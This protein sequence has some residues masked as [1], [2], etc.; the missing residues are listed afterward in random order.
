M[1]LLSLPRSEALA[2]N[3]AFSSPYAN[4]GGGLTPTVTDTC[5]H[6]FRFLLTQGAAMELQCRPRKPPGKTR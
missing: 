4:A 2:R 1:D 5:P 6:W 3:P